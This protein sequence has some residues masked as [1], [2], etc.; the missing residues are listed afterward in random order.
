MDF[1]S[2]YFDIWRSAW[3]LHKRYA[4][5]DRT[6][7]DWGEIIAEAGAILQ[8]YEGKPQYEFCRN[9]LPAVIE[10]LEREDKRQHIQTSFQT[11]NCQK[12]R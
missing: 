4:I 10:E 9:L 12:D 5:R 2:M 1:R 3:D 8:Q 6:E 11:K 7:S